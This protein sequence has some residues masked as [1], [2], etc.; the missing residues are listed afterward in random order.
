MLRSKPGLKGADFSEYTSPYSRVHVMN[1]SLQGWSTV[2][3]QAWLVVHW[4]FSLAQLRI[5]C[6]A[7]QLSRS[8]ML[9]TCTDPP[10]L[11][12]LFPPAGS[13]TQQPTWLLPALSRDRIACDKNPYQSCTSA[14]T[15]RAL[16]WH[17][18]STLWAAHASTTATMRTSSS[19]RGGSRRGQPLQGRQRVQTRRRL[20]LLMQ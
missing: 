1:A 20:A 18:P 6:Q 14:T 4:C 3:V 7:P 17:S 8:R 12:L 9:R 13:P 2:H 10:L 15:C 11:A 19:P 5:C 16:W